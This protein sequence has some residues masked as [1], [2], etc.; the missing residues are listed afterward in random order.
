[1]SNFYTSV[2]RYGNSMLYRG[3][4]NSGEKIYRKDKFS[5]ELFVQ[6][7][8]ETGWKSLY[9][10]NVSVVKKDT[11]REMKQYIEHEIK[12]VSNKKAF[13]NPNYIQT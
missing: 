5:P 12:N 9:G 1:M 2:V 3:Y 10:Q 11:M 7:E 13:G 8:K 4:S 6:S